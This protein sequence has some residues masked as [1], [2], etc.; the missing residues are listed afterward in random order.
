MLC[1][2]S[3]QREHS[4]TTQQPLGGLPELLCLSHLATP[5]RSSMF[6]MPARNTGRVIR[7]SIPAAAE[8][9]QRHPPEFP[10]PRIPVIGFDSGRMIVPGVPGVAIGG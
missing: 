10:L 2:F 7:L 9:G 4:S 1:P 6:R 3:Q 8:A 5:S